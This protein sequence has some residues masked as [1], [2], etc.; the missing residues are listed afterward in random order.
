M[1]KYGDK[2]EL[3]NSQKGTKKDN[4]QIQPRHGFRGG[5]QSEQ[6]LLFKQ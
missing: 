1:I 3:S 4:Q 5:N 2:Y 6:R